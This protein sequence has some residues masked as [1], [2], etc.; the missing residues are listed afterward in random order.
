[1]RPG[2]IGTGE[3]EN[4]SGRLDPLITAV[5]HPVPPRAAFS[6]KWLSVKLTTVLLAAPL[7]ECVSLLAMNTQPRSSSSTP[8]I[9][10]VRESEWDR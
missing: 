8:T 9:H 5:P 7:E 1:M 6:A 4:G 10:A 3:S 2:S